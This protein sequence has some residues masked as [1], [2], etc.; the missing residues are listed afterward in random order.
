VIYEP[1]PNGDGYGF[2]VL[3]NNISSNHQIIR[4]ITNTVT[5]D[6][7]I[8]DD[9]TFHGFSLFGLGE[10]VI[11]RKPRMSAILTYPFA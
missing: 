6:L 2:R 5:Y 9:L 7:M 4:N 1:S 3:V 11:R 10:S 8:S